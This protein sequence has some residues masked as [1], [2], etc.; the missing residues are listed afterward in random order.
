MPEPVTLAVLGGAALTEGVKFLY[1][2][3]GEAIKRHNENKKAAQPA[4]AIPSDGKVPDVIESEPQTLMIHTEALEKV[5]P[6]LNQL[7]SAL[8]I[9]GDGIVPLERT[10]TAALE[11]MDSLRLLLET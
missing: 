3:A 7:R 2:Q 6:E 1:A 11:K 5:E 10:D 9:Y 4:I 8:N